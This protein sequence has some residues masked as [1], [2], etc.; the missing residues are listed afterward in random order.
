MTNDFFT[1]QNA[2][3]VKLIYIPHLISLLASD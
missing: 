3:G 1:L 2:Y